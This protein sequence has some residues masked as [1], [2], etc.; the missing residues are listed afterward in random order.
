MASSIRTAENNSGPAAPPV[1]PA[2]DTSAIKTKTE[3]ARLRSARRQ[4]IDIRRMHLRASVSA[5]H[6]SSIGF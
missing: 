1:G 6:F 5:C 4:P 2:L 3:I